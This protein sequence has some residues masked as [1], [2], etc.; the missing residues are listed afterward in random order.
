MPPRKTV[1]QEL[2]HAVQMCAEHFPHGWA[3]IADRFEQAG[4]EHG[5]WTR[6]AAV[7]AAE[8]TEPT[9]PAEPAA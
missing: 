3:A 5:A 4:C 1:K 9:P 2:E 6:A 7:P 8:Q